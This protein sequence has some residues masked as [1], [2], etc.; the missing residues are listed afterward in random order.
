M[1]YRAVDANGQKIPL[2]SDAPLTIAPEF[3][4]DW[5]WEKE[6]ASK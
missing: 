2:P 6:K 4:T 1:H 5:N 3:I